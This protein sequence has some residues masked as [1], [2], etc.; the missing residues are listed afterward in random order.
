METVL[1]LSP[2]CDHRAILVLGDS[3]IPRWCGAILFVLGTGLQLW[4]SYLHARAATR[5]N[6]DPD[7]LILVVEGP[8]RRLRYPDYLGLLVL[9]LGTALV[10]RSWIGLGTVVFM[11]NFMIMR[12]NEEEQTARKKFGIQWTAYSRNSWRLV[13]YIY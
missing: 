5:V 10:F 12:M 4:A 2:F 3:P 13:P 11:L 9:S 1:V 7:D 6:A 8:F